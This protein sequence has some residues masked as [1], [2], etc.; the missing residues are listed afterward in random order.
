MESTMYTSEESSD[1]DDTYNSTNLLDESEDSPVN[2]RNMRKKTEVDSSSEIDE[3]NISSNSIKQ[4]HRES[5]VY[6]F[7]KK[8]TRQ[9][10]SDSESDFHDEEDKSDVSKYNSRLSRNS[11]KPEKP[12]RKPSYIVPD[13]DDEEPR[14]PVQNNASDKNSILDS[15]ENGPLQSSGAVAVQEPHSSENCQDNSHDIDGHVE[16]TAQEHQVVTKV[17]NLNTSQD[18]MNLSAKM[19]SN[20]ISQQFEFNTE[21]IHNSTMLPGFKPPKIDLSMK[22]EKDISDSSVE[23]LSEHESD[24]IEV[25]SSEAL[26][27]TSILSPLKHVKQKKTIRQQTLNSFVVK[28]NVPA[29]VEPIQDQYRSGV[30]ISDRSS[31]SDSV[32]LDV[33]PTEFEIQKNKISSLETELSKMAN[34]MRTINL[35]ALPD[36]GKLLKQRYMQAQN[37]LE[38]ERFKLAQMA[39]TKEDVELPK[40]GFANVAWEDLQAGVDAVQPKTFGKKAMSTYNNQKAITLDRLQQLHGALETCPKENDHAEDPKGLKVELMPHQKR[41]LAWLTFREKA[42]PSGGILADDMGLG[43]TLTMISLIL[44]SKAEHDEMSDDEDGFINKNRKYNGGSL[45]VCPASLLNQWSGEIDRRLKRGLLSYLVYHGPKRETSAKR[46]ADY[47][48]VITTYSIIN[49]EAEKNSPAFKIKWRRVILDE[50]HQIRNYKSQ[51]SQACCQLSAVSRWALTGTP[52]HNKEL[53]MYALLKY[54]R[55]TPFDD[56]QTWKRWVGDKSTGGL[57]RLHTVISSLM[58]RRTKAE[59]M[60]KGSLT[61]MPQKT[62][63]LVTI[64]LD[65]DELQVYHK[66]LIFSKTLFAQFLHQRAEKD[67]DVIDKKFTELPHDAPNQEYFKMRQ[68]ILKLNKVKNVSQHE[69][70]VLLL[71]LRQ[72]CCHPSLITAMLDE[73]KDDVGVGDEECEELNLLEQLNKLNI[74]DQDEYN[75]ANSFNDNDDHHEKV[76]LKEA[77]KGHLN[78]ADPVF[79]TERSSSKIKAMLKILK[80][81]VLCNDDK[82]I[83]V[84]QWSSYLNLV[85]IHLNKYNV[86]FDQ[87]DGKVPVN[88]RIGI[89]DRFNDPNDSMKVLLLSLTAGGVGLNLVGANHLFLLDLHWN[90]QLENQAQDRIYRVGQT[91][92]VYVYKFMAKDTIEERIKSLQDRKLSM[93]EGVLTGTKQ[94]IQSKLSIDDLK[95]IFGM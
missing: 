80:E 70:L 46:L 38:E 36:K 34:M 72:I 37:N 76:T 73:N 14:I 43:K 18:V 20:R 31:T 30:D 66:V 7:K 89:V 67:Q 91:K 33:T 84:S 15:S 44:L 75:P 87:L 32:K 93:A 19:K 58:L 56:L 11:L 55:C 86:E 68:K 53:D 5:D 54:L 50:A 27:T 71:R 47:D 79:S 74:N 49:N 83:I 3:S 9:I 41:A 29:K 69:I 60:E 92:P 39:I 10:V 35:D 4:S 22:E 26:P 64:T 94:V 63:D 77:S 25:S 52:M 2:R 6:Y 65:K 8:P 28:E 81:R 45:I 88:K 90:P 48:V 78:P 24:I 16:Q 95:M 1:A 51:T 13:S 85:A 82:A 17:P 21:G 12:K 62:W 57:E 61:S 40:P 42:K 59:L 23:I